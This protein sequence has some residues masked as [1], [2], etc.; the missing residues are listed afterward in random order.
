[1]NITD[2][3]I[4]L[5]D[6]LISDIC[7]RIETI[8]DILED[9]GEDDHLVDIVLDYI[10]PEQTLYNLNEQQ[11][12]F[13]FKTTSELSSYLTIREKARNEKYGKLGPSDPIYVDTDSFKEEIDND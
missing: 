10:V 4:E 7:N 8:K 1:M 12:G 6:N 13:I 3:M 5:A 9:Y 11:F 2:D